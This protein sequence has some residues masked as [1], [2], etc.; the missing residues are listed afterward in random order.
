MLIVELL[1]FKVDDVIANGPVQDKLA[2]V[3]ATATDT[4]GWIGGADLTV[5]MV[6]RQTNLIFNFGTFAGW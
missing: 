1:Q 5:V 3:D 4:C 2:R 6:M